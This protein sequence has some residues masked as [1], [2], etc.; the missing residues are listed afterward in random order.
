MDVNV[1]KLFCLVILNVGV[2][3]CLF[4]DEKNTIYHRLMFLKMWIVS[5]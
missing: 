5:L 1:L 3:K 2:L 4:H